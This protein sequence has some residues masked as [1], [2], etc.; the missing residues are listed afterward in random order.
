MLPNS[1]ALHVRHDVVEEIAALAVIEQ[2]ANTRV[3]YFRHESDFSNESVGGNRHREL[4]SEDLERDALTVGIV[5]KEDP[6]CTPLGDLLLDPIS[7]LHGFPYHGKQVTFYDKRGS[8]RSVEIWSAKHE[9]RV[10]GV[11][12]MRRVLL[13][14]A[15]FLVALGICRAELRAQTVTLDTLSLFGLPGLRVV[16]EP[17]V[18]GARQDGLVEET[19]QAQVETK[20]RDAGVR[21]FSE[22]EWQET[23]GN[24]LIRL[25]LNLLKPSE[26]FYLYN[27]QVQVQ[28]LVVLAR[29]STI[30][31]FSTTWSA[32]DVLGTVPAA[33]LTSLRATVL[34][35][36][37]RFISAH[38]VANR[39]GR[40]W[41]RRIR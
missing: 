23:I 19:L 14:T 33:N 13:T 32:G 12:D 25:N 3:V 26:H 8:V 28:Q 41:I 6:S 24:P 30:P 36:V 35:Q 27:L 1:W 29:D 40:R 31:S 11:Q 37:D 5:N 17:L 2:L 21:V 4:R 39:S 15:C 38:A 22:R 9:I 7:A 16:V 18:Q 20:L 34:Q 10:D